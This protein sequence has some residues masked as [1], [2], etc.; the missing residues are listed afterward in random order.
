MLPLGFALD[1]VGGHG[2][3]FQALEGD[4]AA[5]GFALAVFVG[6]DQLQRAL[7]ALNRLFLQRSPV[8]KLPD[9]G[10][11]GGRRAE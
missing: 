2:L 9:V 7:D 1:A 3:D 6:V 5:A 8:K 4:G 11:N 10:G